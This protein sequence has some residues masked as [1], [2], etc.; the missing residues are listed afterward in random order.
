MNWF[1][2]KNSLDSI[3][4]IKDCLQ[5]AIYNCSIYGMGLQPKRHFQRALKSNLTFIFVPECKQQEQKCIQEELARI[6]S[7]IVTFYDKHYVLYKNTR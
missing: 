5:A 1:Q 6:C 3:Y 7:W 2:P 4:K